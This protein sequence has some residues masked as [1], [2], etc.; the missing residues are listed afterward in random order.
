MGNERYYEVEGAV[1]RELDGRVM[2]VW[3]RR[4]GDF[5]PYQGDESRVRRMSNPMS[6][7]EVR[8]YMGESAAQGAEARA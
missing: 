1:F 7:E 5:V 2:E 4:R 8:P 3:S 6:L